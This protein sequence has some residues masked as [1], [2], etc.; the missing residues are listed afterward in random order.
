MAD[1]EDGGKSPQVKECRQP[2]ED[3][4]AKDMESFLEPPGRSTVC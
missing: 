4:K 3:G 2:L 1:S